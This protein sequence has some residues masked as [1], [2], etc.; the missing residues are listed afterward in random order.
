MYVSVRQMLQGKSVTGLK[1]PGALPGTLQ[2]RSISPP[3]RRLID[4]C[5]PSPVNG[6]LITPLHREWPAKQR[7]FYPAHISR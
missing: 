6:I 2:V 7:G 3:V 4:C 1:K 5:V